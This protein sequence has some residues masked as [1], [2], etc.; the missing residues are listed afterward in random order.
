MTRRAALPSVPTLSKYAYH[1]HLSAS[2][3]CTLL[4][5]M[6]RVPVLC[7][8]PCMMSRLPVLLP[9]GHDGEQLLLVRH[10]G[11]GHTRDVDA[12]ALVLTH[13]NNKHRGVGVL[14]ERLWQVRLTCAGVHCTG[15]DTEADALTWRLFRV[16]KGSSRSRMRSI[17]VHHPTL[18]VRIDGV[19]GRKGQRGQVNRLGITAGRCTDRHHSRNA[20]DRRRR[21]RLLRP[22]HV[23]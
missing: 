11:L 5:K 12:L 13:L 8:C 17:S 3:I 10:V 1:P 15:W 9:L 23:K 21:G 7:P 14:S 20:C 6:I 2:V 16:L 19:Q 18:R 22:Y 4:A